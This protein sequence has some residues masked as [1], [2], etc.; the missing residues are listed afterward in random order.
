[1]KIERRTSTL[2][3]TAL[4][5]AV[6]WSSDTQ[7]QTLNV[8]LIGTGDP[9]P[10]LDRFGPATL[11]E[12]GPHRL[13]FDAGRGVTQRPSGSSTLRYGTSTRCLSRTSIQTI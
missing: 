13:L 3:V 2:L 5:G 12:A 4:L 9:I 1:M 7:A 10:R 6:M 11:V 8:T